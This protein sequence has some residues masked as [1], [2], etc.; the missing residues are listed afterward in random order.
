MHVLYPQAIDI[1]PYVMQLMAMFNL[2]TKGKGKIVS[3]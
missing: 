2:R 1:K 3:K